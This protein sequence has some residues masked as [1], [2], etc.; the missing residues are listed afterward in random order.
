[1]LGLENQA[2]RQMTDDLYRMT[3]TL[4]KSSSLSS[5][6]LKKKSSSLTSAYFVAYK[7]IPAADV[8]SQ[9][10]A[11][12]LRKS[13]IQGQVSQPSRA[14]GPREVL[15]H[16]VALWGHSVSP[17]AVTPTLKLWINHHLQ[18]QKRATLICALSDLEI[19]NPLA[20]PLSFRKQH[21]T[22]LRC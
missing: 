10:D 5:A 22:I 12:G 7:E 8:A 18:K 9:K 14:Q 13:Q 19:W 21:F 4:K 20:L 15:S 2:L 3:N 1:M 16:P 6:T 11:Q 17:R